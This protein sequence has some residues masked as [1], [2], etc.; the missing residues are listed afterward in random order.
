MTSSLDARDRGEFMLHTGDLDGGGGSAGQR[1][2]KNSSQRV[3]KRNAV[4]AL[5]RLD[6]K[7]AVGRIFGRVDTLNT[8]LVNFYHK[9]DTLLIKLQNIGFA[10]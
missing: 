6:V 7:Y 8:R 10:V 9:T 1:R 3:A 4:A 2:E 5:Q